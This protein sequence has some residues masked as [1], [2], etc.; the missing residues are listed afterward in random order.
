MK[1]KREVAEAEAELAAVKE[2]LEEDVKSSVDESVHLPIEELSKADI[3]R[4]YVETQIPEPYDNKL[5]PDVQEFI[6]ANLLQERP[7]PQTL[8]S[9]VPA[10]K[11]T[12]KQ[13]QKEND[14]KNPAPEVSELTK[15]IMKKDLLINRLPQFD[16]KPE[17][18]YSWKNSFTNIIKELD[19]TKSEELDLLCKWLGPQSRRQ[20]S[21]LNAHNESHALVK[22]WQRLDER[23][24]AP[25]LVA[26]SLKDRLERFPKIVLLAMKN[27]MT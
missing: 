20:A 21:S 1:H 27:C 24:G 2:I 3:V 12:D 16:D 26:A 7:I 13:V 10:L 15:Y 14:K 22:I 4:E 9:N 5:N 19:A 25:E 17:R 11:T 6:P 23:Y 18:Y 8:Q